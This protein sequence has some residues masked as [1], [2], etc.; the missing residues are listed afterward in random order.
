MTIKVKNSDN[1]FDVI[2]KVKKY[3]TN[4]KNIVINFPFWHEI[5][6]NKIDLKSLKK[7]TDKKIV[8]K[9]KDVLS[10]KLWK[11]LWIEYNLIEWDHIQNHKKDLLKYNYSFYEYLKYEI[12]VLARNLLSLILKNKKHLDPRKKYLKYYKQKWYL[13]VFMSILFITVLIFIYIFIFAVNKTYVEIT[14]NIQIK[15][16]AQNFVFDTSDS[17]NSNIDL[18]VFKWETT[19]T[20]KIKT[21]WAGQKQRNKS[22][23]TVTL[24]NNLKQEIRILEETRLESEDGI[25]Y[26]TNSYIIIPPA[27][28]NKKWEIIAGSKNLEIT[29]KVIDKYWEKIWSRWNKRKKGDLL[30]LPWLDKEIQEDIYA[31]V[32]W[33]ISWWKDIFEKVISEDDIKN[34]KIFFTESIK[35]KISKKLIE[36]INKTNS[37]NNVS[38]KILP[39][40]DIYKYSDLVIDIW[41]LEVGQELEEFVISWSIK[42]ETYTFNKNSVISKLKWSIES[43]I[44]PEKETLLYINDKSL[45]VFPEKWVIYRIEEP[46]KAKVT[47]EIEYHV[48]YNF[49]WEK[50]NYIQRLKQT[51]AWLPI[52]KAEK[53]LINESLISNANIRVRPFFVK[54][55]SKYLNNIEFDT[56]N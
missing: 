1:I 10:K 29:A 13:T 49:K 31:K 56:S 7:S 18:I 20:E 28:E 26:E 52:Q 38:Y 50:D 9:T 39:I 19:L 4:K 2:S 21:T 27:I 33:E 51:I 32:S 46:F 17:N 6:Y 36:S 5:L 30:I 42:A 40:N 25:I 11:D 34:A 24:Y 14:P 23:W 16:K 12:K 53:I 8:I 48:E 44:L 43:S 37:K 55:V 22:R 41:N 54:N 15:T 35:R 47:L 45:G 3:N